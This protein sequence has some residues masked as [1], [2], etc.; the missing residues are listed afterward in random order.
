VLVVVLIR[1]AVVGE[2]DV[3]SGLALLTVVLDLIVGCEAPVEAG[4]VD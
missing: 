2:I 3:V 1:P 4:D